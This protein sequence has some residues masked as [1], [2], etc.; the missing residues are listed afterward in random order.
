MR[1]E[2][3]TQDK[4][5]QTRPKTT[6]KVTLMLMVVLVMMTHVRMRSQTWTIH[7]KLWRV[8]TSFLALGCVWQLVIRFVFEDILGNILGFWL[9]VVFGALCEGRRHLV[10]GMRPREWNLLLLHTAHHYL[11][12]EIQI[13]Q[14]TNTL[15]FSQITNTSNTNTLP[16]PFSQITNT[17]PSP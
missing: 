12:L 14:N 15:S 5:L 6:P 13:H 3:E 17:I 9:M 1:P 10:G 4:M 7:Q 2:T 11:S 16:S 8:S